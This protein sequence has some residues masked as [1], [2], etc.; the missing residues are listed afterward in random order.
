MPTK[1]RAKKSATVLRD[2]APAATAAYS[3][4]EFCRAHRISRALFYILL[5]KQQAPAVM[6]VR[7]RTL[8]SS[9][10]AEAWRRRMERTPAEARA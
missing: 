9:E 6:R 3:I 5:K 8:V 2:Q 4:P 10:A 7:G 1:R